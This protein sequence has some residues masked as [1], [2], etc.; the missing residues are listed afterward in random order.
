MAFTGTHPPIPEDVNLFWSPLHGSDRD[1]AP[2]GRLDHVLEAISDYPAPSYV[3]IPG[4]PDVRGGHGALSSGRR[5]P[6]S[7][8]EH[9][10]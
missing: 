9:D 7:H 8:C 10:L 6:S 3:S 4:R 2:D 1:V 5:G